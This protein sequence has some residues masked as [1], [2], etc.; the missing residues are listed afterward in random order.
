[1]KS[2]KKK[3]ITILVVLM[4]LL[5]VSVV[6]A[7]SGQAT[8]TSNLTVGQKGSIK[9]SAKAP[10]GFFQGTVSVGDNS[11]I[12]VDSTRIWADSGESQT[13]NPSQTISLTG[14]KVG[15][16]TVKVDFKGESLSGE[17]FSFNKTFTVNVTAKATTL[18]KAPQLDDTEREKKE[19]EKKLKEELAKRM[20]TPLITDI[21]IISN[22][23]RLSGEKVGE[24]KPESEKFNYE[25]SLPR[26]IDNIKLK[27]STIKDDVEIKYDENLVFKPGED[28]LEF[29]IK[30][31]QD[32]LEQEFKIKLN[33][34]EKSTFLP[35]KDGKTYELIVDSLLDK[36]MED[37][38]FEKILMNEE[39]PSAGFYYSLDSNNYILAIDKENKGY[40]F[41]IDEKNNI[42]KEVLLVSNPKNKASILVNEVLPED[43]SRLLNSN[44][45]IE[46]EVEISKLITDLD[47]SIEF[48][49]KINGWLY[50][51]ALI[52]HGL[53]SEGKADLVHLDSQNNMK[54]AFIEFDQPLDKSSKLI[55]YGGYGLWALSLI[56]FI[57]YVVKTKKDRGASYSK[58]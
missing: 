41:L 39:D 25:T 46:H 38:G 22:S 7:S 44:E 51:E 35:S 33:K 48:N 37:L 24:I 8:V 2:I 21:E 17:K 28:S 12:K 1:M 40:V 52:T 27:V 16:S 50:E 36:S 54:F 19:A 32:R 15:K 5:S 43:D 6:Y 13:A 56:I 14:L 11:V 58:H 55:S 42:V 53:D 34:P 9:I 20:K 31:T 18:P 57:V 4:L 49:N 47:K 26:N 30:A 29:V 45:Y 23:D 3:K 10:G